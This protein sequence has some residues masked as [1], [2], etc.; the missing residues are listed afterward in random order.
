MGMKQSVYIFC[1]ICRKNQ[2]RNVYELAKDR[3]HGKENIICDGCGYELEV[4]F[5]F[6]PYVSVKEVIE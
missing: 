2:N 5:E 3:N 4:E 6:L 1:P